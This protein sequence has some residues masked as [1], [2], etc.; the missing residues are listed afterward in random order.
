M[1]KSRKSQ[2]SLELLITLVLGFLVLLPIVVLEFI[3][4]ASATSTLSATEAQ[5]AAT[6]LATIATVVG[7]QGFPAKQLVLVQIP[8]NINNIFVGNTVNGVGHEVIFIVNTNA[9]LS[10]VT[11][12]TPL[13][14]S[15]YLENIAQPGE[16]MVNVS[17]QSSCPSLANVACVYMKST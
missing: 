5:E 4:I 17:A 9:G 8:P 3:Q 15:G 7:S 16:Y 14:V 13:N 2:S 12:Y 6:K 1:N 10:Y 11:A